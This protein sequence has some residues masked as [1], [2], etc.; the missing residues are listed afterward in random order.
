MVFE[1]AFCADEWRFRTKA[2]LFGRAGHPEVVH[3][4]RVFGIADNA[5]AVHLA[6][7]IHLIAPHR[8]DWNP[9]AH[10]LCALN[11]RAGRSL[12]PHQLRDLTYALLRLTVRI[13]HLHISVS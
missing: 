11:D 8:E 9:A 6:L 5:A 3:L 10:D 1:L 13:Q 4:R 7:D 2:D 12:A